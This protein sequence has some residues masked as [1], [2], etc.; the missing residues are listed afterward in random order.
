[1]EVVAGLPNLVTIALAHCIDYLSSFNI[2]DSL[3]ATKFFTQFTT[4]EHMLLNGN[5]VT[6]LYAISSWM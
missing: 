4:K 6:N 1:M 3:T 2:A 5:T